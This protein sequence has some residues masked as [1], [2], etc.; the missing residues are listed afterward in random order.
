M[1][2]VEESIEHFHGIV[3]VHKKIAM[4]QTKN[5]NIRKNDKRLGLQKQQII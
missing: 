1:S 3:M 5:L 2:T 4:N